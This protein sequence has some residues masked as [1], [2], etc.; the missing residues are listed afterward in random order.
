MAEPDPA[1]VDEELRHLLA[2]FGRHET[3]ADLVSSLS[4]SA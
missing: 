2:S 3:I 4:P 1:Q